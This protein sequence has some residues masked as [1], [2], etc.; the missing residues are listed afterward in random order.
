MAKFIFNM[1]GLLNIKEKLEEQSKTEYG[2]ALSKL[3]QEKNILLNLESKKQKNILSFRESIN[4]GVKPNYIG[5]INKYISLID[6]KIAE[7]IQNIEKAKEVVE[8]K[9]LALLEAM[10][11]RKVLEALKEKEKENYFKEEIKKEQKDID[12]IVSYKYNKA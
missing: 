8:E 11:E 9:R 7:Q 12:E 1:Q 5:N 2:K 3:E 6:K 10:K 4:N